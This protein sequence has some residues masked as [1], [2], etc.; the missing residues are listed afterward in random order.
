MEFKKQYWEDIFSVTI[1][2]KRA[3]FLEAENLKKV[4]DWED[5]KE[6]RKVIIDLSKCTHIDQVFLGVLISSLK[7]LVSLG[8]NLK[9]VLPKISFNLEN[10]VI[11]VLRIFDTYT[12]HQEAVESY[13]KV[14]VTPINQ[15]KVNGEVSKS[16]VLLSM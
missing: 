7:K 16:K 2:L 6:F 13:K 14:F 5:G 12:T 8:G 3:T 15:N 4:L 9:I 1:N 10:R 11:K